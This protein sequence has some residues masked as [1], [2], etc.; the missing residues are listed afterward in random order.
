MPHDV[1]ISTMYTNMY[2]GMYNLQL[3]TDTY[4]F[5]DRYRYIVKCMYP[6]NAICVHCT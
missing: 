2:R 4:T 5:R 1:K 3:G 6:Q